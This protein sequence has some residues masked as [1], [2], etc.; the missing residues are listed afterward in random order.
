MNFG[1]GIQTPAPTPRVRR[2]VNTLLTCTALVRL[3]L[4]LASPENIKT[5]QNIFAT[6]SETNSESGIYE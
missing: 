1:V 5:F 4:K 6:F 3:Y 2:S